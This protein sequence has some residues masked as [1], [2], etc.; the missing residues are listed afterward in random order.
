MKAIAYR[1]RF[2]ISSSILR[3]V[4]VCLKYAVFSRKDP[5][6][7]EDIYEVFSGLNLSY[8]PR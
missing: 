6:F 5:Y 4:S 7:G 1:N 8:V 3:A 2:G